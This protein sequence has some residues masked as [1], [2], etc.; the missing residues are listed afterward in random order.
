MSSGPAEMMYKSFPQT[1]FIFYNHEKMNTADLLQE[2][3]NQLKSTL[4]ALGFERDRL[5]ELCC[6]LDLDMEELE[7]SIHSL[8]NLQE[9]TGGTP[10][11][12]DVQMSELEIGVIGVHQPNTWK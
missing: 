3:C 11:S 7:E 12:S 1:F 4:Q 2:T 5:A 9:G 8:S 6:N 10:G